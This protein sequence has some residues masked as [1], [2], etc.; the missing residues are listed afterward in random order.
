MHLGDGDDDV[1]DGNDVTR[2]FASTSLGISV[3]SNSW[4]MFW[5][6]LTS[7][8]KDSF[9]AWLAIYFTAAAAGLRIE[10]DFVREWYSVLV[11]RPSVGK[12]EVEAAAEVV[13]VNPSLKIVRSVSKRPRWVLLSIPWVNMVVFACKLSM[14]TCF[15]M[16][17]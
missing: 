1:T 8:V 15:V 16:I 13:V 10:L 12:V 9:A 14:C 7:W 17:S 5:A 3:P 4:S 11:P 2:S 6:S